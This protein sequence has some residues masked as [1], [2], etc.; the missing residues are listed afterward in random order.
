MV[1]TDDLIARGL[2][3]SDAEL[4]SLSTPVFRV[5]IRGANY[6]R[7]AELTDWRSLELVLRFNDVG[8]W[9]LETSA[10]SVDA[11]LLGKDGGIIVTRE[12]DGAEEIIFS[13][14]VWTEWGWTATTFRAAGYSD[15]ALLWTPARPTP[16][17]ADPPFANDYDVRTG[18]ASSVMMELVNDNIG[19]NAPDEWR[20]PL[21]FSAN[22]LLGSTIT[23]RGNRN[24]SC[25]C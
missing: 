2:G 5:Y 15:E 11:R 7:L 22:P 23:S 25:R 9:T 10:D 19:A 3:A 8:T 16:S 1:L 21:V 6:E 12:L 4:G 20:V 24:R 13:G 14:F 18:I 17:Q